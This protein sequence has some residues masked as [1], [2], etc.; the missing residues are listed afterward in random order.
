M[1]NS[2]KDIFE[3]YA[4]LVRRFKAGDENA[5]TEIYTYNNGEVI[6]LGN[7]MSQSNMIIT[8]SPRNNCICWDNTTAET[9]DSSYLGINDTNDDIV[10]HIGVT[11]AMFDLTQYRLGVDSSSLESF[12]TWHDFIWD[13]STGSYAEL[14][15]EQ[16]GLLNTYSN[17][18][19]EPIEGTLTLAQ[20]LDELNS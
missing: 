14:S 18:T 19:Y 3:Q 6:Q 12:D 1:E 5:F 13:T 2:E 4:E 10:T 15:A 16:V 17:Y 11:S 9:M 20:L 8:Y 7:T